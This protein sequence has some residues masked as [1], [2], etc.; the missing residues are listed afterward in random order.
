[1]QIHELCYYLDKQ[2]IVAIAYYSAKHRLVLILEHM[3]ISICI[4]QVNLMIILLCFR[5]RLLLGRVTLRYTTLGV[6][7]R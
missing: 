7:F 1:M 5:S 2:I 3:P 6:S 4:S